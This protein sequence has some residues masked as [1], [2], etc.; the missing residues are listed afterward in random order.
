M[1]VAFDT[2]IL[3]YAEGLNGAAMQQRALEVIGG[4]S[5]EE[6]CVPVQ[7]LG[8]LFNMLTHKAARS[9]EIVRSVVLSW[10]DLLALLDTS[11]LVLMAAMDLA[12]DHRLSIWDAIIVAAAAKGGCRLL[13]SEDLQD[14]FTWGGVTVVNPFAASPQPLLTALLAGQ[15]Q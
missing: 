1:R 7:V 10:R 4:L 15:Q 14:G 8:E 5:S 12:A 3:V 2:N 11:S 6:R 9:R 13:L